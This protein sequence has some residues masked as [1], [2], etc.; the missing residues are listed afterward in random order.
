MTEEVI[1]QIERKPVR[2]LIWSNR[3]YPEYKA[4]RFGVDFDQTLGQYL[5]SHYHRVRILVENPVPLREWNAYIW[6]RKTGIG[7]R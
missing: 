1:Q 6:E 7:T 3:I 5:R 4:L 2:Y